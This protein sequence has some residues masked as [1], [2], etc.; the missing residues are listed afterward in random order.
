M[1]TTAIIS[2]F[3]LGPLSNDFFQLVLISWMVTLSSY[4]IWQIINFILP[5]NE[6]GC[7]YDWTML[8][9][10]PAIDLQKMPILANYL[11][12]WYIEKPSLPKRVTVWCG[13][14]SRSHFSSKMSK[15]RP[16]QS[17][18]IVMGQC[19]KNFCSQK[20]KRRIMATFGFNRTTLRATQPKLRSMFCALFLKIT[21]SA[22][23]LM[24]FGHLGA[25]IWYRWTII[26]GCRQRQSI[27]CL[28]IGPIV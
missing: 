16:L 22:T 28:K 17:M 26:C 23:E 11:F 8:G 4:L 20:L 24:S 14:W 27:M 15:N 2:P 21:L 18:S 25:A 7:V 12:R 19:W 3:I 9:T 1:S 6:Y 13:Y 10:G 5:P